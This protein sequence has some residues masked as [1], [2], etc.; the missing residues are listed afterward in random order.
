M[1]HQ[2]LAT[3]HGAFP[4]VMK[5]GELFTNFASGNSMAPVAGGMLIEE[6]IEDADFPSS[7]EEL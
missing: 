5:G 7:V 6:L 2:S 4:A 1:F 3:E